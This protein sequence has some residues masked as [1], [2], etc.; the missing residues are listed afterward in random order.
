MQLDEIEYSTPHTIANVFLS[1][2]EK[3]FSSSSMTGF[4][5]SN[6][7]NNNYIHLPNISTD[8]ILRH[9]LKLKPFSASGDDALTGHSV[10]FS[11][12]FNFNNLSL[13]LLIEGW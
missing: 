13:S 9:L 2:F 3:N 10:A 7:C 8:D 4:Q 1:Y 12:Q 11:I 6:R 5:F